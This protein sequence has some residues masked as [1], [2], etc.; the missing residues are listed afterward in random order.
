MR[1][2]KTVAACGIL[3]VIAAALPRPAFA[4]FPHPEVLVVYNSNFPD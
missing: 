3:A 4:D 1:L 2:L